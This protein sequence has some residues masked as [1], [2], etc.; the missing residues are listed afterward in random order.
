[1]KLL[2]TAAIIGLVAAPA[3]AGNVAEPV[4]APEPVAVAPVFT[5]GLWDGGYVGAQLGWG[6]ADADP[7]TGRS[8][9]GDGVIGGLNAGYLLSS[10]QF[11]YG[12]EVDYDWA[13]IELDNNVGSLD[14]IGRIKA[15]AGYDLGRTLVYAT[16]GG[17]YASADLGN[18]DGN[19]W[20]WVAGG[21]VKYLVTETIAVGGEVLYQ[22]FDDFDDSDADLEATT[23]TARVTYNF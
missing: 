16:A 3:F 11:V 18:S 22:K 7:E 20:G 5:G 2:T 6:W 10:G 13:D 12:G 21:G 8:G 23:V 1:M 9:S 14:G 19:D 4:I 17:A 15:I